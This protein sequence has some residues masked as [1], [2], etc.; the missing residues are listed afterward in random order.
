MNMKAAMETLENAIKVAG[1]AIK[2]GGFTESWYIRKD[3]EITIDS[4]LAPAER[5]LTLAHEFGH[6]LAWEYGQMESAIKWIVR[7]TMAIKAEIPKPVWGIPLPQ[8]PKAA[9]R[10]YRRNIA[11]QIEFGPDTRPAELAYKIRQEED[12]WK[13]GEQFIPTESRTQY[14]EMAARCLQTYGKI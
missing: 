12:A 10:Q 1:L 9:R 13:N 2:A 3:R 8:V 4:T 5:L 7:E 6:H 11:R 14:W